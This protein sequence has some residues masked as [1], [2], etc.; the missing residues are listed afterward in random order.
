MFSGRRTRTLP[1]LICR[2]TLQPTVFNFQV[3]YN[4]N[5][6]IG[7]IKWRWSL[8]FESPFPVLSRRAAPPVPPPRPHPDQLR[9]QL[10]EQGGG[11]DDED[12]DDYDHDDGGGAIDGVD[13][14]DGDDDDK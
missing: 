1:C 12:N 10:V 3:F 6:N 2:P 11:D 13:G 7:H 5:R 14:E 4:I 8:V 9:R